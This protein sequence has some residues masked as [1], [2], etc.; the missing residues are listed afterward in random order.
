MI[1]IRDIDKKLV[2][3]PITSEPARSMLAPD[4]KSYY[5]ATYL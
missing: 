3:L 2:H 1:E 5:W 4:I